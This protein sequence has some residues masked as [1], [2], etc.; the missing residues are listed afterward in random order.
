MPLPLLPAGWAHAIG[1]QYQA[2]PMFMFGFLLTVFPRWMG[3]KPYSR[4][5]YL[6]VGGSLLLGYLLFHGG[7]LGAP[8]LAHVGLGNQAV[9]LHAH[10]GARARNR[11][12]TALWPEDLQL[13]RL[14]TGRH[15]I[16]GQTPV[17]RWRHSRKQPEPQ[18]DQQSRQPK[19][20]EQP[21]RTRD[22]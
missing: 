11:L 16:G 19:Q 22:A 20:P 6:P 1:M 5:H 10:F 9:D 4:W 14:G 3:L 17:L 15:R 12:A 7:L 8:V 2:L 21:H 13:G 18:G